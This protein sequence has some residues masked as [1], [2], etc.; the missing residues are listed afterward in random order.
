LRLRQNQARLIAELFLGHVFRPD[1]FAFHAV[2][3]SYSS[4]ALRCVGA[5]HHF[6]GPAVRNTDRLAIVT[7]APASRRDFCWCAGHDRELQ[8]AIVNGPREC[9]TDDGLRVLRHG[10]DCRPGCEAGVSG[11][12]HSPFKCDPNRENRPASTR[13]LTPRRA[14][15]VHVCIRMEIETASLRSQVS[16]RL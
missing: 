9:A 15:V 1:S 11:A 12:P 13:R 2:A 7:K 14:G 6:G 5:N 10:N 8:G 4:I 3:T 16:R